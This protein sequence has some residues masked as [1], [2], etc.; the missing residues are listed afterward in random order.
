MSKSEV[1]TPAR[2]CFRAAYGLLRATACIGAAQRNLER[3]GR[4]D[5]YGFLHAAERV[6]LATKPLRVIA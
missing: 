1:V 3:N 2:Q 4:S 5:L 6:L